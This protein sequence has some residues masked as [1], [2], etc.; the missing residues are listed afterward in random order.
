MERG[1]RRLQPRFLPE[2]HGVIAVELQIQIIES[3]AFAAIDLVDP[4]ADSGFLVED[5]PIQT[6]K[7]YIH[8]LV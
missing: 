1:P 7:L 4:L 6:E 2:C 3:L 8:D 5:G